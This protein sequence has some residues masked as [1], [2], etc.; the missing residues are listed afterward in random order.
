MSHS[1]LRT[2]R[3]DDRTHAKQIQLAPF[4]RQS[5]G[6]GVSTVTLLN[7]DAVS[8][9]LISDTKETR[10]NVG[11]T[12]PV[13]GHQRYLRNPY[14]RTVTFEIL[15]DLPIYISQ[16][17]S[18]DTMAFRPFHLHG[19]G[20]RTDNKFIDRKHGLVVLPK[21]GSFS[22]DL[23]TWNKATV[24]LIPDAKAEYAKF[25]P[26]GAL[27]QELSAFDTFGVKNE[28]YISRVGTYTDQEITQWMGAAGWK[29]EPV[30]ITENI[31]TVSSVVQEGTALFV[32][33]PEDHGFEVNMKLYDLGN[34]DPEWLG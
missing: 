21:R 18:E 29:S 8:L 14:S 12:L 20:Y 26:D 10:L 6:S 28:N 23:A 16:P 25:I 34:F 30:T 13:N 3:F 11:S 15:E 27:S 22:F 2:G 9:Q 4:G 17:Q 7:C 5:L 31:D 19:L 24:F 32:S 33:Y 1:T